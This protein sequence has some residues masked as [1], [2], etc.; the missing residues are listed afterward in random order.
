MVHAIRYTY[1]ELFVGDSSLVAEAREFPLL[2][3][4]LEKYSKNAPP[5]ISLEH[6]YLHHLLRLGKRE[7]TLAF[8]K[9]FNRQQWEELDLNLAPQEGEMKG[10]SIFYQICEDPQ[11]AALYSEILTLIKRNL[12]PTQLNALNLNAGPTNATAFIQLAT[13]WDDTKELF[14]FFSGLEPMQVQKLDFFQKLDDHWDLEGLETPFECIFWTDNTWELQEH[15]LS[16]LSIE[17]WAKL[18]LDRLFSNPVRPDSLRAL[19]THLPVSR[20]RDLQLKNYPRVI[21]G[22]ALCAINGYPE[23]F[24]RVVHE[25]TKSQIQQLHGN[26]PETN[27]SDTPF[28]LTLVWAG[29]NWQ[30]RALERLIYGFSF[31][32][33]QELESQFQRME[34]EAQ[35]W[36][37][38]PITQPYKKGRKET[39][40]PRPMR[41]SDYLKTPHWAP[42]IA[43]Y[44]AVAEFQ[45]NCQEGKVGEIEPLFELAKKGGEFYFYHLLGSAFE[46]EGLV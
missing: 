45:K 16:K 29:F 11:M 14:E 28:Y 5:S 22:L 41:L 3:E 7:E 36:I 20:I 42:R 17:Q 37:R 26:Y 10:V 13:K 33:W 2:A 39:L 34:M 25:L 24:Y 44:K 40:D 38:D 27:F 31:V 30:E 18:D 6:L 9:G 43:F 1:P 4:T 12:T 32:Q 23:P 46:E 8:L 19:F 21:E 15:L 35:R